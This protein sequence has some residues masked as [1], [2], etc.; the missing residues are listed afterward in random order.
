M[1]S[2]LIGAKSDDPLSP[3]WVLSVFQHTTA[4]RKRKREKDMERY[5][6]HNRMKSKKEEEKKKKDAVEVLLE[7]SSVPDAELPPP[8]ED[9]QQCHDR[10]CKEKTEQLQKECNELRG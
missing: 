9:E 6:Q 8:A 4:T 7:L 1:N 3:D 2:L 10:K 5:E